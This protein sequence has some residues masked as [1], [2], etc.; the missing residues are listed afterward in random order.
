MPLNHQGTKGSGRMKMFTR[1]HLIRLADPTTPY[2]NKEGLL[3]WKGQ[4][5][6][7]DNLRN[8]RRTPHYVEEV[9]SW[10]TF[11]SCLSN[12]GFMRPMWSWQKSAS[13]FV[14]SGVHF[15]PSMDFLVF[16]SLSACHALLRL[17]NHVEVVL[18]VFSLENSFLL[19]G[20]ERAS[21]WCI[22]LLDTRHSK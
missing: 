6:R 11:R 20:L 10:R 7:K 13:S 18:F 16:W 12:I 8:R 9:F 19:K 22:H 15:R 17:Q 21:P 4:W 5:L 14:L 2:E 1:S 3:D